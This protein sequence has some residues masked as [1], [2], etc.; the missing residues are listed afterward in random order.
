M[1]NF[2][3]RKQKTIKPKLGQH[4]LFDET[5]LNKI[6]DAGEVRRSDVILEIGPGK[7]DLTQKLAMR[8]RK[9][10][11]V[12]L[13]RDLARELERKFKPFRAVVIVPDDIIKFSIFNFKFAKDYKVIGNIPFYITGKIL[14]KFTASKKR[15][16]MMVLLVQKEVA[17]RVCARPGKMS[18]LTVAVQTF[19]SPEIVDY[20]SRDKF[21]PPPEVDS[22]ILRIRMYPHSELA[23]ELHWYNR[24]GFLRVTAEEMDNK[25]AEFFRL[26]K[27]GF[28][29]P[30]KQI[31]NNL[32]NGYLLT[33]EEVTSWLK[34][35]GV[36]RTARAQEL[37]VVDWINLLKSKKSNL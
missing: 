3:S 17:K 23:R 18:V 11:A 6:V 33:D 32:K 24:R 29:S 21:S 13:D 19:G 2:N 27:I 10:V 36:K 20:V 8:A 5:I 1:K 4:F 9:V 26:I 28:A 14:R 30:R 22:A 15:P 7:G 25:E 35:A 34:A 37:G 16:K 12:E 31:H